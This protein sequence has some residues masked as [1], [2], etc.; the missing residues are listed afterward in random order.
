M[1]LPVGYLDFHKNTFLNYQFNRWYST[2]YTREKD[3]RKA[4]KWMKGPKDCPDI[5]LELAEDAKNDKRLRNAAF[6]L[7][8]AAFF[9]EPGD[10]RKSAVYEEFLSTFDKAFWLAGFIRHEVPYG[11]GNLPVMYFPSQ[12]VDKK[13]TLLCFG[14]FDSFVEEFYCIWDALSRE[15]YD[16]YAFDG[17]GQGGA[18][19][20]HRLYFDHDWE[21]PVGAILD[22]FR[23][24]RAGLLGLSMGGYWAIRAAAFERR[25]HKVIAMPP[26]YDW[27]E[28]AG[29]FS[30]SMVQWLR[31][32]P[33]L[34]DLLVRLKMKNQLLR[35]AVLQANYITGTTRPSAAVEW[36]L[37]M[38]KK[39]IHS[40]SVSQTCL[41][42]TGENDAFQPPLLLE[43]QAKA[44]V[45]ANTVTTRIFTK[46]EQAGQHCQIGNLGLAIQEIK[47][48]LENGTL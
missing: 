9:L 3:L 40:G 44:L 46:E 39:H 34:M 8:G 48:W 29:S 12:G 45:H 16:I 38:N 18:L 30:K 28:M 37:G 42:M 47:Y 35:H 24:T 6:Y 11:E 43:A 19:E 14:G 25:I 21:K 36:M 4:A 23:I 17:P 20:K 32:K 2:G 31:N 10:P 13:E 27:M 26:V 5:M 33:G 41:L 22:H 1:Q 7:R 15:G